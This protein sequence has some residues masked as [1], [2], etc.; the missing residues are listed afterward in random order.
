MGQTV[1]IIGQR[2]GQLL[3][4]TAPR[5]KTSFFTAAAVAEVGNTHLQ[6]R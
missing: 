4:T 6:T 1:K 3:L 2:S 5:S